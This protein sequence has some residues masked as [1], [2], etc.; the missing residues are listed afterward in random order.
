MRTRSLLF[1]PADKIERL[2]RARAS[3][4]DWMVLDLEDGVAPVRKAPARSAVHQ[5]LVEASPSALGRLAL[6]IN[7]LRSPEGI[8]DVTMLLDT[9][10]WP[11]MLVLPKIES[12]EE[13]LQI[14]TLADAQGKHP[15]LLVCLETAIGL[16][17][18]GNI[19][20]QA[21]PKILAGYGS[22]DHMA[23]VGG[24][25]SSQALAWGR[26]Q[27][28]NAAGSAGVPA[29]DG[30]CLSLKDREAVMREARLA[31][32]MGFCGK[33][34]IHP[35]QIDPINAVFTPASAEVERARAMVDASHDR[36]GG[37]FLFA[38]KMVD[39]PVLA[40]AQRVL[41][42]SSNV[43]DNQQEI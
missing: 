36:G 24:S 29:L 19:F 2:S 16:E 42:N 41:A 6:R 28:L 13:V 17:R 7:T 14:R 18:A 27:V 1:T 31:L 38:G 5:N 20:R 15:L 32:D 21:G 12:P 23:E 34:A 4:T 9:P 40:H 39:A 22:A 33:L 30:V 26:G 11:A 37:A 43:I 35:A 8:R 10:V 3:G 25:M